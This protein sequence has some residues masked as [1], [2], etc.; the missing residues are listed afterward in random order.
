VKLRTKNLLILEYLTLFV[1]IPLLLFLHRPFI[2]PIPL[3][4]LIAAYGLVALLRDPEF[5]RSQL[6]NP[7]PLRS[8]VAS[9]LLLFALGI[10]LIGGLVYRF[11]P[12]L[13]FNFVRT[14]PVVWAVV[15]LFYP[16]LSVYPQ[17]VLFRAFL[18]HRYRIL[19]GPSQQQKWALIFLSALA[20]SLM[21]IVFRNWVAVI[22]TF[23]G[24]IL[25]ARRH[26]ETRSL[27]VSSFEHALYGCFVF[28]VGL[29]Q[30]FYV[31]LV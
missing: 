10:A 30:F 7:R 14:H 26:L 13:L 3:L 23:A 19:T 9:I 21:H 29:S 2:P 11:A 12:P 6:W 5:S 28:T 8:Q 17:G 16:V 27:F 20:F 1:A 15:M 4:W 18:L 25:F 24:G 31:R 22:L